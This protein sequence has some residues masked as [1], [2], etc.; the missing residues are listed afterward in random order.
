MWRDETV[1]KC[2]Q[3]ACARAEV[4]AFKVA[5]WR[6]AAASI[7]KE[8][9]TP[10]KRANFDRMEDTDIPDT[11]AEGEEL[12]V[13]MAEASN[14]TFRTFNQAYAGSMT[15]T[16]NTIMHRAYRASLSWRTLFRVDDMLA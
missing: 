7:T 12:L 10:G 16:M 3:Q 11:A 2:L 8:K 6:Q 5:W 4:P 14:H 15:L 13:D 1:S 9:F